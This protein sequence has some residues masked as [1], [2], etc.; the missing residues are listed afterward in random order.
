MG[1]L[2][3]E[4]VK[5][6]EH[7]KHTL[8]VFLDLSKAFD[9]LSHKILLAK[10]ERYGIRGTSWKWYGIRGTSWKWY[11]IRGTSWKWFE[12]YLEQRK[13]RIKCMTESGSVMQYPDLLNIT[14]TRY[15]QKYSFHL[16]LNF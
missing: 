11:G 6:Q 7:N 13:L 1:E 9:T 15:D 8:A 5:G 12:S 3:G 10:L 14:L 4:I 2:I 16:D